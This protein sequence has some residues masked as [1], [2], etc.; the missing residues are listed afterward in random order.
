MADVRVTAC[1]IVARNYLP[2]A[3]VLARS[4]LTQ[5]PGNDFV[6]AVIDAHDEPAEQGGFRVVGWDAFGIPEDDYLRM[7]TAYSVTEL[8]TS[9]KPY[10]LRE[11]RRE[12]DVAIY[13]DP[14]IQV[15]A[16]MPEVA[17]LALAHGI[18]LTPHVLS[19][20]PRDGYEPDEAVIMGAGIFNLGFIGVG[21]GSGEFLDFWAERLKHDA[22]V[23]PERQLFTDQRWVDNVPALF[24]HHVLRDPGFNVAYWNLHDRPLRRGADGGLTAGGAA[25]RFFHFSGYRPEQPWL[26]TMYC[27]RKPRV[28]L[29]ANPDLRD[30]CDAYGAA[31]R[32]EGYAETLEAV[33]YGFLGFGDGMP[34]PKLARRAFRKA[35][36][37]AERKNKPLPPHAYGQDGGEALRTWLAE[38]GDEAQA[39]AGL[40][41][42]TLAVWAARVDLR[43]AFPDPTG[44]NAEG[45][46]AWCVTSGISEGE[47]AQWAVPGQPSAPRPPVDEFGVNLLGYLTAELGVGEMGRI[48]H[49][50]IETAGIPVVS[51]LEE[52]SVLN[53]TGI[54]RPAT[55]GDPRFPISVLAVNADMT[56]PLLG[57]HRE[58][59]HE[60]YRI[61]LWAWE[62]EDFPAWQHEAFGL[63]DEVWTVSDFCRTAFAKHSPIPVKTI[64]VPVRDPGE[65]ARAERGPGDP[66]RFLFAFDFNSIAQRKNP[67]GTVTAFQKAFPG[68]EDVRLTIKTINSERR[69]VEAERLRAAVAG[70]D[71]I[72][73]LERYLSLDELH[74]LYERSTCYVSLH[75]SEGFGLTVAEAMARAM[76]VIS[77]DYSSTTEFLDANTGWPIP[78]RLV[79]VGKNCEP[80]EAESSWAD[81]DLDAAAAA[82]RQVADDPAEAARRG[83]E[84][85]EHILR[86]R[87]MAAAAEWMRAELETAYRTWQSRHAAQP[88]PPE[89]PLAPVRAAAE[90][91]RWRPEAEAPARIPLAPAMRKAVLR[92]I[93]HYDVHQRRVMGALL[94]GTEDT[95]QRLLA[96]LESIEARLDDARRAAETGRRVSERIEAVKGSVDKR[97][98]SLESSL[99]ALRAQTPDTELS[100]RNLEADVAKLADGF[101][102]EL[103]AANVSTHH[104]FEA[105]DQRLDQDEAALRRVSVDMRAMRDAA[106]LAHAPVPSGADV[107]PCD[108]GALLMPVDEVMLPWIAFH[109]SWEDSEAELM[110]RLATARPGA[111]LDIGAHVGYHTL[112]LL[113]SCPELT[114]VIAVEAHPVNAEYLRRNLRVNLPAA[115]AE[116]TTV[117]EAAAWDSESTVRLAQASEGNSGDNRVSADGPGIEV[118]ALRLD[119]VAEVTAQPVA[120]IKVD[121]QG[122]DHRALA[123]LAGTLRRDRPHVVCEFCPNA[124]EELG[125]DPAAVLA[126]YRELGYRLV[127]VGEDGADQRERG[128]AELITRARR[129]EKEFS[130]LWLDPQVPAHP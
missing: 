114:R 26:L 73:L 16:P 40:N 35:W 10:L 33:P 94:D 41:R 45:F 44:T 46:R 80:Y 93:D 87:S 2:A 23:A 4:Y 79:Q 86:T 95:A 3:K 128:D 47:L 90:A 121:L 53:R 57:S 98:N 102:A 54:D 78:Y 69:P 64:P 30:L 15:F 61:G 22:I 20:L 28:M 117:L 130:T 37:K 115:A 101:T 5:H 97:L 91:L 109:R 19:P 38:P 89:H 82:M 70:D 1:T 81:P 7:A 25:L 68:R 119:E 62:L 56:K 113:R 24:P 92:A 106:R 12:Y 55:V 32:A 14:D 34:L 51:V 112:R 50:A 105:R 18:V 36:I 96:R 125:D 49:E 39:A 65:P 110:A 58:V 120:L 8:A 27:P 48:V 85:R 129:N 127:E 17:E 123:G 104:M 108:V 77:T 83:R 42:M 9:V 59:G 74:E 66:V 71:R 99:A 118:R 43:A 107:V 52:R 76:P 116:L 29:S 88:H 126:G 111:I 31:L 60:R 63:L 84:A 11:L 124:I 67:W 72:E 103:Q 13:L 122:R 75:R 6:I 100:V 21:P